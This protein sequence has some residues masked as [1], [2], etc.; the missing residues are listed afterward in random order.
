MKMRAFLT[1][2]TWMYF[3]CVASAQ[4]FSELFL[5]AYEN[6]SI[7]GQVTVSP[8]MMEEVLQSDAQIND[9]MVEVISELKSLRMLMADSAGEEHFSQTLNVIKKNRKRYQYLTSQ[10]ETN[11]SCRILVRKKNNQIVELVMVMLKNEGFMLVDITGIIKP[12]SIST[13]TKSLK[14]GG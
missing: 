2:C 14:S 3:A 13:L 1:C 6:D 12:E 7:F 10:E 4:D 11:D 9:D 8:K 5:K